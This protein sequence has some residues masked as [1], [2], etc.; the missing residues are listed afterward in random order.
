MYNNRVEEEAAVEGILTNHTILNNRMGRNLHI[1]TLNN[2]AVDSLIN[3]NNR[4]N[5]IINTIIE[6]A[7]EEEFKVVG[8]VVVAKTNII[9]N[10]DI[11]LD[12]TTI[13]AVIMIIVILMVILDTTIIMVLEMILIEMIEVDVIIMEIK[14]GMVV[15]E[16]IIVEVAI[17]EVIQI[18]IAGVEEVGD[19][20]YINYVYILTCL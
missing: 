3:I 2:P 20:N 14:K 7:E 6:E 17:I 16:A 12:L 8:L 11:I 5:K 15:A 18:I 19:I 13:H 4:F 9:I 1:T 10:V